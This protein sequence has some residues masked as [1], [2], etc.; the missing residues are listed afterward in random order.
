M[1]VFYIDAI[2]ASIGRCRNGRA[3][4]ESSLRK[5]TNYCVSLSGSTPTAYQLQINCTTYDTVFNSDAAQKIKFEPEMSHR[6]FT[7]TGSSPAYSLEFSTAIC[8]VKTQ[9]TAKIPIELHNVT[10]GQL[11]EILHV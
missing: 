6:T 1:P 9:I 8:S 3:V 5:L 4:L 2:W 7:P 11:H 10:F